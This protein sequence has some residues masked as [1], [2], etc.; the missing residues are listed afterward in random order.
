MI[1]LSLEQQKEA[2]VKVEGDLQTGCSLKLWSSTGSRT[3]LVICLQG[4]EKSVPS[5]PIKLEGIKKWCLQR[6]P[7]RDQDHKTKFCN[8]IERQKGRLTMEI[9]KPF[10]SGCLH[11]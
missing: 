6:P 2:M 10:Q 11:H 4:L 8:R 9:N 5:W 3:E 1:K 7:E